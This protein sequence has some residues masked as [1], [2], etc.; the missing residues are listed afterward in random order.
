MTRS[1]YTFSPI[2]LV[3]SALIVGTFGAPSSAAAATNT[4]TKTTKAKVAAKPA[5]GQGSNGANGSNQNGPGTPAQQAARQAYVDCLAKNGVTLPGRGQGGGQGGGQGN[6]NNA[7]PN[8]DPAAME[9]AAAACASLRPAGG[10][11]GGGGRQPLTAKEISAVNAYRTCMEKKGITIGGFGGGLGG[12]LGGGRNGAQ[13]GQKGGA[14]TTV[15]SAGNATATDRTSAA[16]IAANK[17]CSKLLPANLQDRFT[18]NGRGPGG[19]ANGATATT[20]AA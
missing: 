9:K 20:K 19:G 3:V 13:N 7:R 17:I 12:G 11:F 15:A 2:A 5:G 8:I 14:P 4:T 1:R 6:G 18:G 10:G 16:F